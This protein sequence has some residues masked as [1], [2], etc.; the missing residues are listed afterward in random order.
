MHHIEFGALRCAPVL[1]AFLSKEVLP[2]TEITLDRFAT[3][4]SALVAEFAPL[5]RA[6][7]QFRDQ[8][9][10]QID[11]YHRDGAGRPFEPL[12]YE[13]FLR[14][15]GYI[16]PEPDEVAIRTA[17]VDDAIAHIAGP[18]LV[19]PASNARYAL[20]AVNARWGSLYDALYGTDAILDV[21]STA[22]GEAFDKRRAD[23]VIAF[24]KAFLDDAVPLLNGS[25][26]D[27]IDYKIEGGIL[28]AILQGG[29]TC[30][31]Q[32]PEQFVGFQGEADR[33]SLLLL[34]NHGLHIEIHL[35]RTALI[36]RPEMTFVSDVLLES[37]ITTI[38]DLEDSVAAVDVDDKIE[39][40]RC[41]LGLMKGTLSTSFVK[42]GKTVERH[43]AEPRS[44][45]T[46]AGGKL[47]LSSRSLMLVRNVGHHMMTDM[48]R[49]HD[50]QEVPEAIVDAAMTALI[51][52]HDLK[53][54]AGPYNSTTGSIYIVKPKLH[55]P[56]EVELANALFTRIEDL[57]GLPRF[58]LKMG[59]MDEERRTTINLKA[60]MAAAPDRIV[61]I[62]TG[63]LDR[64]GDE[65]HTSIE[66]GPM[67]RKAAMKTQAWF[68]AYEKSNV[69]VGLTCGLP[70]HGQIGKGM[71]AAPDRMADMLTHK[72]EHPMAGANTAW[73][74]SPTAAT[75][76]ALHYHRVD[77][78]QRQRELQPRVT[79]HL[80]EILT[81][82]IDHDDFGRNQSKIMN[83][84]D[85]NT[86]ERDAGEKPASTFSHP[87]L[88]QSHWEP[89]EVQQELD[90]NCQSILGYV[91]RW[92][93]Q[94]IGC[95]KVLDLQNIAL[96]EDRATLRISSQHV[97]NWLLHGIVTEAQVTESLR[98][99]AKI[100]DQQNAG[101]RLYRPMALS[102]EGHAFKAA[103]ELV[104]KGRV[105]PNGYTEWI[106]HAH[107]RAAKRAL[108]PVLMAVH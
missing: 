107:R 42:N 87:A 97:A 78:F 98:R 27:V 41:W 77:V 66:A 46:P 33:P 9:Q 65:I 79:S 3:G 99:M 93:D 85:S 5:I 58:T 92:V 91:V 61:F 89:A 76:H 100:V 25:H 15:I 94:G 75:L 80:A 54:H 17:N 71:W 44:Y 28:T 21:E 105:Q 23:H 103:C 14:T 59:V 102:Y 62:N 50:G 12:H 51:G 10:E 39:L 108:T 106:L 35:G 63:F 55:G 6:Q 47:T 40:Y 43:L 4:L 48:L 101:D 30:H 31:L 88:A 96:M 11:T 53:L 1:C 26:K 32:R 67:V 34:V 36:D 45:L 72:I 83:E 37:A 16:V 86:L 68:A 104:F 18:Q 22:H 57:L 19:V 84:I 8:L 38:V 52:M 20:N 64:T 60:C 70:G 56:A 49:D 82:P 95:S 7:L 2:G 74:P 24:A 29:E 90:N 73:V 13:Q 81:L 69:D